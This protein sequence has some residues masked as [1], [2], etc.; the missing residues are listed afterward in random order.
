MGRDIL[1]RYALNLRSLDPR[2]FT[3]TLGPVTGIIG[4][5]IRIGRANASANR[6]KHRL[7]ALKQGPQPFYQLNNSFVLEEA[8]ACWSEIPVI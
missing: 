6:F 2:L 4:P 5:I 8:A 3:P 1:R 7:G